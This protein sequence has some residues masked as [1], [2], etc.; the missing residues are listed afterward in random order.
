MPPINS[1]TS[2]SNSQQSATT[3]ANVEPFSESST[4]IRHTSSTDVDASAGKALYAVADAIGKKASDVDAVLNDGEIKDT[5]LESLFDV[6]GNGFNS[7]DASTIATQF[8][9]TCDLGHKRSTYGS[10]TAAFNCKAMGNALDVLKKFK[11]D[12]DSLAKKKES[13]PSR[14]ILTTFAATHLPAAPLGPVSN[15]YDPAVLE[16]IENDPK[17]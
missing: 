14:A 7:F 2:G 16:S 1:M 3:H 10:D 4:P 8:H 11:M 6:D 9:S 15:V 12:P 13:I 5:E 17:Y